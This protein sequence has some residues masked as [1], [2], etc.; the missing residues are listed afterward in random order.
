MIA[1]PWL[2]LVTTGSPALTGLVGFAEMAPYVL[3]QA[4]GGPLTDRLGARRVSI[5]AD[6]LSA[7]TI[8]LVPILHATDHL[9]FGSA[10]R[11]GRT[12]RADPRPRRRR[13][14][15]PAS[16]YRRDG[17]RPDGARDG[18][19]RRRPPARLGRR[20][21]G[22]RR[23]SSSGSVRR[24]PW[25]ST[26]CSFLVCALLVGL[27]VPRGELPV[28][29]SVVRARVRMAEVAAG[30]SYV[31]QLRA[32]ASFLRGTGCCAR[33]SSWWRSPTCW[34]RRRPSS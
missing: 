34:T 33:S 4:L 8:A 19:R 22:C 20:A 23:R 30:E 14:G 21:A 29:E 10:A 31:D 12:D 26:L 2:V 9:Q 18:R 17:R 1:L 27:G 24:R 25:R 5:T 6:L 16:G 11:P 3:A 7:V 15:D 13:Q 28:H 32:G